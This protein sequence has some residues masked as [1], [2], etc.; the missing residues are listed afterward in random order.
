ME[1]LHEALKALYQL[2][3]TIGSREF[4]DLVSD[5]EK[6]LSYAKENTNLPCKQDIKRVEEFMMDVNRRAIDV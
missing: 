6:R 3:D 5:Y 4:F 2:K 1:N